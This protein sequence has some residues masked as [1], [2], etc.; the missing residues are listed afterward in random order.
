LAPKTTFPNPL[1]GVIC[2][3]LKAADLWNKISG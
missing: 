2:L 3:T 1:E